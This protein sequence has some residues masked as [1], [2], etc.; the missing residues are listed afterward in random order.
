[1][2]LDRIAI[3]LRPRSPWEAMDLGFALARRSFRTLWLLWLVTAL[4][5]PVALLFLPGWF[6]PWGL[7]LTWWLKPLYEPFL[8][9]W[10]SRS[11][12]G[13]TLPVSV[14][15]RRWRWIAG[16]WL[17]PG[18]TWRRF[19]PDRSFL[20]PVFLLE[21]LTGAAGKKRIQVLG[22][23][24][25]GA[26]WLTGL[27]FAVEMV[28]ALSGFVLVQVFIPN[29]LRWG[30]AADF[31]QR[32]GSIQVLAAAVLA[33]S[34]VGPL[35]VA[36]GFM[37][38]ISRRVDLEGWDI[39][40]G[41]R[42]MARRL[43]ERRRR[44]LERIAA[45]V[46]LACLCGPWCSPLRAAPLPEPEQARVLVQEIL[47]DKTFGHRETRY[48]WQRIAKEPGNDT[49][50]GWLGTLLSMLG[51]AT[52]SVYQALGALLRLWIGPLAVFCK[53]A[54]LLA[55][56][57]LLAWGLARYQGLRRRLPMGRGRGKKGAGP[58]VLFGMAVTPESLPGDIA[59]ACRRLLDQDRPRQALALLYRASLS[60]L[61]HG[62][63]LDIP[64]SA[65]EAECVRLVQRHR[66]R[67]QSDCFRLLT[68]VWL[69]TAYGHERPSRRE[70][71]QLIAAWSAG[72]AGEGA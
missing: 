48:T 44:N 11:L 23:G 72:F 54:L 30:A 45:L 47:A 34:L 52:R 3:A 22:K 24:Q 55:A 6:M 59:A 37:L 32:T 33:M 28:L 9:Y 13:E 57:A 27:C 38:Y 7:L 68:R 58:K 64:A 41:F 43:A 35:Y 10:L 69:Q 63:G 61:V 21:G 40:L 36:A 31:L 2:D 70:L 29:E 49:A 39:E 18:L 60:R 5:V 16:T 1:M 20:M 12:F 65:T 62:H 15:L 8:L 50:M 25:G 66:G 71:E 42:R 4:P 14:V 51:R 46:L 67:D 53:M 17:L 26:M 56:G 19:H